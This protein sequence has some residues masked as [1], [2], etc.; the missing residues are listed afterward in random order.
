ME[1][2]GLPHGTRTAHLYGAL[3][4][5]NRQGFFEGRYTPTLGPVET[6]FRIFGDRTEYGCDLDYDG[7]RGTH[8]GVYTESDPNW[9]LGA[10]GQA[11]IKLGE[12][13]L[14]SLGCEGSQQ[15]FDGSAHSNSIQIETRVRYRLQNTYLQ[16]EWRPTESLGLT[17]GIQ[18]AAW[19]V[20]RAETL[21]D[22]TPVLHPTQTRRGFTPRVAA[23]WQ[24]SPLDILKLLYG[25]GYRNPTIFERYYSDDGSILANP[26]LEPER[27]RT[28]SGVW[29]HVWGG[30]I[31]SQVSLNQ[32]RWDHLIQPVVIVEGTQQSQNDPRPLQGC[33]LETELQGRW[34]G[35]S[36]YG[37]LGLYRWTQGGEIFPDSARVQG[38]LRLVR[39]WR[40]LNASGEIRYL[41]PRENRATS[42]RVPGSTVGRMSLGWEGERW[43]LQGTLEDAG[44]ARRQDLVATD[45]DPI[46]R[47]PSD[48][49]TLRLSAG[50]RF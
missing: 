18:D 27:I 17:L 9:S 32:S 49:R 43:W 12:Q 8:P 30:G 1:P 3:P 14:L 45:Y 37:S 7:T 31:Q 50:W 4:L 36:L 46:T 21:I 10:E 28:L 25:T 11:R 22:G 39:H 29:V 20:G 6:L 26:S 35:W 48:G 38:G 24:P 41:G 34:S 33:S 15:H 2:G 16:G 13:L 5:R 47:M 44:N 23:V 40:H 19:I 42:A